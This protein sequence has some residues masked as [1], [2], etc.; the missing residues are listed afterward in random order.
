MNV[1]GIAGTMGVENLLD[2]EEDNKDEGT[3]L[4]RTSYTVS[5]VLTG[6]INEAASPPRRIWSAASS[7]RRSWAL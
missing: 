1:G 4:L 7:A 5:A 6:N 3:S 2:P